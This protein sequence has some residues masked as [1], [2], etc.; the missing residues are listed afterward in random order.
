MEQDDLNYDEEQQEQ[1]EFEHP[2]EPAEA[3]APKQERVSV[4][5]QYQKD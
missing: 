5:K 2:E 1:P 3:P 4:L